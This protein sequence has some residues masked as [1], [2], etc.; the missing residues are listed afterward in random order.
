MG[1]PDVIDIIYFE[2]PSGWPKDDCHQ[3][4]SETLNAYDII[5]EP[6]LSKIAPCLR[7]KIPFVSLGIIHLSE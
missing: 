3:W 5:Y 1:S 4:V 7:L 2:A 6:P